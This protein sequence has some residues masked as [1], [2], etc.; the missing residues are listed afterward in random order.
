MMII[1]L[2]S[3]ALISILWVFGGIKWRKL[4]V[5]GVPIVLGL[6]LGLKW[7]YWVGMAGF[8]CSNVIRLGYGNYENDND[9]CLLALLTRDHN[10]W[11]IRAIWG[12][13]IS[14]AICLPR[15]VLKQHYFLPIWYIPL[16]VMVNF[17]VSRL[18]LNFWL[19]DI[20]VSASVS[21]ILI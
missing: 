4:R 16:N 19:T 5:I 15:I 13:L 8:I 20:L 7:G 14:I 10:G 2:I 3:I 1:T 18:K 12:L 6:I 11:W 17:G 21:T 9:D